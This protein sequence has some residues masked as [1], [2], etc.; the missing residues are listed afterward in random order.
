MPYDAFD[1]QTRAAIIERVGEPIVVQTLDL[2]DPREGEVRVRIGAAG[3]CHSDWHVATGSTDHAMPCVLGHEGA[4]TI[5]AVGPNVTALAVGDRVALNWAPTCGGCFYCTRGKPALCKTYVEPIWAGT[6]MDGTTRL[7]RNGVPVYAFSAL[8][9][10]A[11]HAVVPQSCCVKMPDDVPLEVAALIGCAVTTGVGAVVNTANVEPGSTV[12]IFGTGGVGLSAVLGARAANCARVIAI[13]KTPGKCELARSLGA[14]HALLS[15][16]NVPEVIRDL[17]EGRGVDYAFDTTGISDAQ[18][19]AYDATRPGGAV[20]LIGFGPGDDVLELP[21]ADLIRTEKTVAGCYYGS[22]DTGCDF[23]RFA[24]WFRE[25][26]LPIDRLVTQRYALDEI[27]D[28]YQ[29][30]LTGDTAR[31]VIVFE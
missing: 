1:M 2:D 16:P 6:M 4:G 19:L 25:G 15:A 18:R 3:V 17:T 26:R 8:G 27:N 7:S 22:G 11:E 12:A 21:T 14:D 28:A 10:F 30:M 24:D 5:E 13:D 29:A 23:V 9:C 31:G 20:V